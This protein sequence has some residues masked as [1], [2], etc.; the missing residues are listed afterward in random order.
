M[1][2]RP[3]PLLLLLLPPSCEAATIPKTP[4]LLQRKAIVRPLFYRGAASSVGSSATA[5]ASRKARDELCNCEWHAPRGM[6]AARLV[7]GVGHLHAPEEEANHMSKYVLPFEK[8]ES[9]AWLGS[10]AAT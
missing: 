10:A 1:L 7:K 4:T 8:L 5:A 9:W 3:S 2:S 6:L